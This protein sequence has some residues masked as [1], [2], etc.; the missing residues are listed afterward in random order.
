MQNRD[1]QSLL[2]LTIKQIKDAVQ[3]NDD[4]TNLI[5][6]GVDVNN[7]RLFNLNLVNR[8]W[9]VCLSYLVLTIVV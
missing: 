2:P 3:S 1:A 7:V 5:I 8:S 4:K 6:D 9:I